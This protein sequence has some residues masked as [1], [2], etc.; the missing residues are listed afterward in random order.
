MAYTHLTDL[1]DFLDDA[2]DILSDPVQSKEI[3]EYITD[4]VFMAS[5]PETEY[6]EEYIV[7]CH[8]HSK[9]EPCLGKIVGFINQETDDIMWMCPKC[10]DRGIISNWRGTMWDL[11]TLG[12]VVN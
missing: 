11:S 6:P 8:C 4:I 9:Q 1:T 2:G 3:G 12:H 10:V 5:F 7:D